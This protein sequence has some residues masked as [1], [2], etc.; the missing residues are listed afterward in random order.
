[1][2]GWVL[3]FC[4]IHLREQL[5]VFFS[6]DVVRI[7]THWNKNGRLTLCLWVFN[8]NDNGN[9]V[10]RIS[11]SSLF[12]AYRIAERKGDTSLHLAACGNKN[13]ALNPKH[14]ANFWACVFDGNPWDAASFLVQVRMKSSS[15]VT[16][17]LEILMKTEWKEINNTQSK[18]HFI[19]CNASSLTWKKRSVVVN[20]AASLQI[21]WFFLSKRLSM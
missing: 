8:P 7:K 20:T 11:F 6:E 16:K 9:E 4:F 2:S 13:Q 5:S 14:R 15:F 18:T 21:H 19:N 12:S 1:M 3:G 10:G 17:H